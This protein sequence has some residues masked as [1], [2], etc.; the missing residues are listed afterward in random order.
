MKDGRCVMWPFASVS[1]SLSSSFVKLDRCASNCNPHLSIE[2]GIQQTGITMSEQQSV[3]DGPNPLARLQYVFNE[4]L[5][6]NVSA[7]TSLMKEAGSVSP[8]PSNSIRNTREALKELLDKQQQTRVTISRFISQTDRALREA[9]RQNAV[10]HQLIEFGMNVIGETSLPRVLEIGLEKAL[11]LTGAK[12]GYLAL[13]NEAGDITTLASKNFEGANEEPAFEISRTIVHRVMESHEPVL[14]EDAASDDTFGQFRSVRSFQLRSVLCLPLEDEGK[15]IGVIYLDNRDSG[16]IFSRERTQ[17]LPSFTSMMA[18]IV[19]TVAKGSVGVDSRDTGDVEETFKERYRFPNIIGASKKLQSILETVV[20]VADTTANVLIQGESGTGKELIARALHDNSAR[21][22]KPFVVVNASAVPEALL[23]SE[24]FGHEKGAFT[25]ATT[26]RLGKFE[27]ADGGTLFLDEIGDMALGLQAKLLRA[28]QERVIE[29]VG[30]SKP[31][32]VNVRI[33]AATNRNLSQLVKDGQFREDLYYRLYVVM[34]SLPAL[35]ERKEDIPHLARHFLQAYAAREKK[36]L[37]EIDNS[38]MAIL[39]MYD[40]PGNIRQLS[41]TMERAV[42]LSKSDRLTLAD[43]PEEIVG[44]GNELSVN[45]ES[46]NLNQAMTA[47]KRQL[48]I[49]ALESAKNNKT[50]AARILGLSR[51]HLYELLTELEIQ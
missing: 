15:V 3:S 27:Q 16:G 8:D 5:E 43:L 39:S 7:L 33:V 4:L 26:Q 11:T 46:G 22:N 51:S 29:R 28:I 25:G 48:I 6:G 17:F 14:I 44:S 36:A 23:E 49:N 42:I 12:R 24:F 18:R 38:A 1:D 40:W 34:I 32:S 50:E 9:E 13:V 2:T 20:H 19:H 41:N 37:A 10:F 45:M 21:R 47:F 30:G 35:R 31:I